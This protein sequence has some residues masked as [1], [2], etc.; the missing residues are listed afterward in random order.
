MAARQPKLPT[1]MTHLYDGL[2]A[3]N[4]CQRPLKNNLPLV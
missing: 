4:V 3:G 2:F 1:G